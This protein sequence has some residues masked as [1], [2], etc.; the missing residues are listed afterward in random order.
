MGGGGGPGVARTGNHHGHG[1][2][3]ANAHTPCP[4]AVVNKVYRVG[5]K[6]GSGSFG[7]LYDGVDIRDG[8][9]VAIKLELASTKH[10]Q[11]IYEAKIIRLLQG[12]VGVP[13]CYHYG[14]E[15]EWHVMVIDRL[16]HSLEDLFNL[17]KRSFSVETVLHLG[18]QM[19][20][21]IEYIHKHHCIHR[22]IKPDNFLVG[23]GDNANV[24]YLIDF[25]L[26][27]KF[28]DH[29]GRHIVYKEG[30][31]LTGTARYASLATHLGI[32]QARRDD[33][34]GLGYVL[35]YFLRGSLPWQGLKA[36]SKRDKYS[37]ITHTKMNVDIN[38]LCEGLPSCFSEFLSYCRA[39]QFTDAPNCRY[40][41]RLLTDALAERRSRKFAFDWAPLLSACCCC[42]CRPAVMPAALSP[43]ALAHHAGVAPPVH[44][45]LP[46]QS[47]HL[48]LHHSYAPVVSPRRGQNVPVS[49]APRAGGGQAGGRCPGRGPDA[50][51]LF[52]GFADDVLR[53]APALPGA[54]KEGNCLVDLEEEKLACLRNERTDHT[55]MRYVGKQAAGAVQP[56]GPRQC[57]GGQL[58]A[59][60]ALLVSSLPLLRPTPQTANGTTPLGAHA[61]PARLSPGRAPVVVGVAQSLGLD[62]S[63]VAAAANVGG[64]MD[65]VACAPAVSPLGDDRLGRDFF[66]PQK[67]HFHAVLH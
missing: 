28:R 1:G 5:R 40:L 17:C 21:R 36:T 42:I 20:D 60:P 32:E 35:I 47:P 14:D 66:E 64:A 34:E 37:K 57:Y 50:G 44:T 41:R 23:R 58:C 67:S 3:G 2:N 53:G 9:E 39:L 33:L 7:C 49:L 45:L 27:K 56:H 26:A 65:L 18:I 30:K 10:P 29:T 62:L 15:G 63:A 38:A 46:Q 12:G 55:G 6:I 31:N 48:V 13:V 61:Q 24:V 16:G 11:L 22:D 4:P 25:G 43:P 19:L 52:L 51:R 8:R 54:K 59:S